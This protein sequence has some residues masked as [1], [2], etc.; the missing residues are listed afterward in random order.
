MSVNYL[1]TKMACCIVAVIPKM[2]PLLMN[3]MNDLNNLL[4]IMMRYVEE[5]SLKNINVK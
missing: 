4:I 3:L 5:S 2:M 1:S